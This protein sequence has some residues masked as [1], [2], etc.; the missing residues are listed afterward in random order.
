MLASIFHS[1]S[2]LCIF[3]IIFDFYM[4]KLF[5]CYVKQ[6]VQNQNHETK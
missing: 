3:L 6:V 1:F 4:F 5:F 2:Y